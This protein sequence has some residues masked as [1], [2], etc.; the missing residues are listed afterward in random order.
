MKKI[1]IAILIFLIFLSSIW[2]L[3]KRNIDYHMIQTVEKQPDIVFSAEFRSGDKGTYK[4]SIGKKDLEKISEDILQELSYSENYETIIAVKWEDDFQG[5]VELNMKDYTYNPIID[6]ET[7]NN[8]AKDIGLDEIK[9]RSF[10]TANLHMPKY[11]KDGYTFFWGDWRDELC[12]LVKE[13]GVWNMYI[14][15]SSDSRNYCYFIEGRDS[16]EL[17]FVESEKG[18][19]KYKIESTDYKKCTVVDEENILPTESMGVLDFD[20]NMDMTYDNEKIVYYDDTEIC[21]YDWNMKEKMPVVN[22]NLL[23]KELLDIKLSK[24]EEYVLY[25]VGDI[26]FFWS[27]GYRMSFF[28]VDLNTGNKI[29]TVKWENGDRFYGIDW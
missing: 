20:G 8:C 1:A 28:I 26:P 5:L 21:I 4:Y 17:L 14:L 27:S 13:D 18:I 16:E 6:L 3:Y 7:L 25:T 29:R 23:G 9:Y 11:F 22:Q 12:Y 2:F 24:G 19:S 15:Y 10:D